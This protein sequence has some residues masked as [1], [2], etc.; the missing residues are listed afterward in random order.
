M[1]RVR[2]RLNE[3]QKRNIPTAIS[4]AINKGV[5]KGSTLARRTV[6]KEVGVPQADVK[7]LA[8]LGRATKQRPVG[9]IGR[10]AKGRGLSGFNVIRYLTPGKRKVERSERNQASRSRSEVSNRN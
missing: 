5:S 8:T 4:R 2:R 6:A 3:I 1:A 10:K 9:F 7:N